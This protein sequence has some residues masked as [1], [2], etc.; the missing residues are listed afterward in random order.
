MVAEPDV[1]QLLVAEI[2]DDLDC[3]VVAAQSRATVSELDVLRAE[4]YELSGAA[5][6]EYG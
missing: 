2:L 3:S 4:A 5:D 1:R 6:A